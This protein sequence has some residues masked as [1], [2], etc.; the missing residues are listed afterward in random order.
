MMT[1]FSRTNTSYT[2]FLE[3]LQNLLT[4]SGITG[5]GFTMLSGTNKRIN[6]LQEI[7]SQAAE[8]IGHVIFYMD[9]HLTEELNLEELAGEINLSK[10][11]LI[12][13]FREETG[14][15]PWRYLILKRIE[16]VKELLENGT[17]PA[18]AAVEAGFYDQSHMYKV[19]REETG[20]TPKEYMEKNFINKN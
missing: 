7:K 20:S 4:L 19:F 5:S 6:R 9:E 12:R 2:S 16:K 11:Q 17:S 18:Q 3:E 1:R 10:Y 8:Q 15:T 13:R 14:T